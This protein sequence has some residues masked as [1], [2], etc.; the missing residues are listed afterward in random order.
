MNTLITDIKAALLYLQFYQNWESSNEIDGG[1][2][3]NP[4]LENS[5]LI[6]KI[7]ELGYPDPSTIVY[8][9]DGCP[10]IQWKSHTNTFIT[11]FNG[12]DH[13]ENKFSCIE[14]YESIDFNPNFFNL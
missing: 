12:P 10:N 13:T 9:N 7:V 3:S 6:T 1:E 4:I 8:D 5:G 11:T 2:F 14:F